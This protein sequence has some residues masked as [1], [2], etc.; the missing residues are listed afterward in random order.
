M[1][2][3]GVRTAAVLLVTAGDGI[4][5]PNAAHLASCAGLAPTTKSPRTS[6]PRRTRPRGAETAAQTRHVLSAFACMNADTASRTYCDK[7]HTRAEC[8]TPSPPPPGL[9]AHQRPV[10]HAPRRS[11]LRDRRPA[12]RPR[13][14]HPALTKVIEA[15]LTIRIQS[16]LL[17]PGCAADR[18]AP[19]LH[20]PVALRLQADRPTSNS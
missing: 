18:L 2:G 12:I 7:Q 6:D 13:M 8:P 11:L 10:P 20:S 19:L 4:S 3:V 14:T 15:P 1:P 5:L 17:T 16:G 9:P